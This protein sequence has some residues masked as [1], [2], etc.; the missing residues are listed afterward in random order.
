[1]LLQHDSGHQPQVDTP[2]TGTQAVLSMKSYYEASV[3]LTT[4]K[5]LHPQ[6]LAMT[7]KHTRLR[8]VT[9]MP[10]SHACARA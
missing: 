8:Q 5:F 4:I 1:M 7:L 9:A 6:E 3:Y 10:F 2:T